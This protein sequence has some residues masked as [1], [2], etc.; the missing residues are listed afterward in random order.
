MLEASLTSRLLADSTLS[1]LVGTGVYPVNLPVALASQTSPP[2]CVTYRTISDVPTFT[3][4]GSTVSIKTRIEYNSWATTYAAAKAVALAIQSSLTGY[5][6]QLGD[7][8]ICWIEPG[9]VNTDDLDEDSRLY[10]VQQD[11][12]IYHA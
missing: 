8:Y 5:S 11:F 7:V 1:G 4:N 12:L 6:G 10:R 9:G 3:L 2:P